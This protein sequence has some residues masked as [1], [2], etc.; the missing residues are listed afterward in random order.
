MKFALS[1]LGY[2]RSSFL[3]P[4]PS[5]AYIPEYALLANHAADQHGKGSFLIEQ[6]VTY[7]KDAETFTVKETW[8]VSNENRMRLTLE[9]RGPLKGLVQGTILYAGSHK[10]FFD[11][12]LADVAPTALG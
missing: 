9:G 8:L 7:R 12:R 10:F 4:I 5:Y 2:S 11:P 6:E 1:P 3:Y